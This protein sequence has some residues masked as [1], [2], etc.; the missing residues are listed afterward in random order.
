MAKNRQQDRVDR[1][2]KTTTDVLSEF[3]T[4]EQGLTNKEAQERLQQYGGNVFARQTFSTL[5]ILYRQLF[6]PVFVILLASAAVTI[7]FGEWKQSI[8]IFVMILLAVVL[9]F[10]NEY[11]AEKTV[12]K[13]KQ[14]VA[15]K[16]LVKRDGKLVELVAE[17]IVPGDIVSFTIGD[18]IPADMRIFETKDLELNE[19][20]LTGESF[21]VEKTSEPLALTTPTPQQ[22]T[23]YVFSGTVVAHGSGYGVVVSTGKNT[24]LGNIS[25]DLTRPH[26]MTEFQKGLNGYGRLL[27]TLTVFL[28]IGIF[29]LNVAVGRSMVDAILFA[30]AVAIGLV[31]ELMPAIVTICVSRGASKMAKKKVIV[32]RLVSIEDFGNMDVL[33]TDKTG[34][35]TEGKISLRDYN[36][37][38]GVDEP[39]LVDYSLLCNSAAVGDEIA[40]NPMDVAIWR[41][42]KAKGL[43]KV[44][45]PYEKLEE[46]PFDYKR[47]MLSVVIRKGDEVCFIT[48]GAPESVLKK[49]TNVDMGKEIIPIDNQLMSINSH[50]N[51]SS[52][53]GYRILAIAYKVIKP[54]L[55]YGISDE[56]NLTLLGF[57]TFTDEPKK[58]AKDAFQRLKEYNVDVKILTGDNELVARKICE[59]IGIP[60]RRVVNGTELANL[61]NADAVKAAEEATI[62]AR[63]TPD[64]KLDIIKLLKSNHHVV[65]FLGDGVNDAPALFEADVG[66]SVD[67]GVDVAKEAADIVLLDKD[68]DVLAN[69]IIEG[70][71]IFANTMKYVLMGTSSNFGNMFS[72]AVASVFLPFLPML[73]IQILFMNILYDTANMTLPTDN[74]DDEHVKKPMKWDNDFVRKYTIFFG[75]FSSLYDFLTYGIML[76]IFGASPAL[77][78]SG[79]FVES[80]WTEVLVMWVIRTKRVPFWTSRPGKWVAISTLALVAFGTILPFTILGGA[81][82]F[83]ALPAQYWVLLILMVAT[84]LLLVDMGKVFFLKI[85]KYNW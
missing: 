6:N 55:K 22:L 5:K 36:S 46:I 54:Q 50:I 64:Q 63:I 65:G 74:V 70:R 28:G 85:C 4:S 17:E 33:C 2:S 11:K 41:F 82:G 13:L 18:I 43:E 7:I 56:E 16:A 45:E 67:S 53:S 79:W 39:R 68:L 78:Q 76:F 27:L 8:A 72:V 32:K 73:P 25:L 30:L 1:W 42:A 15:L 14:T 20:T 84:Y 51:E 40:G 57:L 58:D 71:K 37:I 61:S 81:L 34:T 48:K 21:P 10:Y 80:F 9:G 26:P 60:V 62:F 59:E 24:E 31:P 66:I 52:T 19:A 77:F 47:R 23:N 29:V 3:S 69:G 12:E 83:V 49:C 75:P 38:S 44:I 35:L